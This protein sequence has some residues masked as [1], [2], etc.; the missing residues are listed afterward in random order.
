LYLEPAHL[1][2]LPC[3][4]YCPRW[5]VVRT[6]WGEEATAA[7]EIEK[8]G[9]SV[10]LPQHVVDVSKL[11]GRQRKK[12]D[13]VVDGA[14]HV[15][16]RVPLFPRYLFARFDSAVDRWRPICHTRGVEQ[17]FGAWCDPTSGVVR[18]PSPVKD[19]VIKAL[20]D[21]PEVVAVFKPVSLQGKTLAIESGPWMGFRG[22]CQWST[23]KRV[24]VLLSL[25]GRETAV[26]FRRE[27]VRVV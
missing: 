1:S 27:Q 16:R 9:F 15:G 23:E 17:L 7:A 6:K 19:E 2:A 4:S 14:G 3:G 20:M 12:D 8:Q 21:E 26:P 25:F 11:R 18:S 13:F 22:V 24:S 5:F 10:Y